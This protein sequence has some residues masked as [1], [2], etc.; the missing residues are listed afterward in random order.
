MHTHNDW[1]TLEAKP[2]RRQRPA[3]RPSPTGRGLLDILDVVVL[4]FLLLPFFVV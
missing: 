2:Q 4:A 1:F 3:V